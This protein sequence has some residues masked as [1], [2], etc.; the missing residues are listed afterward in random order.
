MT[1]LPESSLNF[2]IVDTH[3]HLWNPNHFRMSWLDQ[4]PL[5]NQPYGLSEYR[6][7]TAGIDIEAMVYVQVEVETPYALLEARW[8]TERAAED[9]RLQGIVPWA[10]LEYGERARAFLDALAATSP[11][12]KGI[13][14][15]IQFEPDIDFCLQPDFVRGVQ[16]LAE[17]GWSFD[18]CINHTQMA[19]TIELVRRCPG[20]LFILD[21]IGKP[22]IKNHV[23]DPWRA[24]I[25][26]LA[27]FPNVWCKMSGLTV[28]ADRQR[29]TR[30]DLQPY[31][32]HILACFGFERT[33]FGGDWPV[34][35]QAARYM[36]WLEAL[37][38]AVQ[39]CSQ[40]ELLRLFH[41][42]ARAFYRL[43]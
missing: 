37:Q 32:D 25:K 23:L 28:E 13:R 19:N 29:W 26:T 34:V 10:P 21:H 27:G 33:V 5:L 7:H 31:I 9:K 35:L 11:L 2:P 6:Q 20:T 43:G 30:D 17:Y 39:G 16:I 8:V 12:I 36:Q 38:W 3:L 24:G 15:I 22:D 40:S 1:Q 14:R 42:N 4:N 41:D 18:I